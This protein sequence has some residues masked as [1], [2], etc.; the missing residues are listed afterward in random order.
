MG[1]KEITFLLA[2]D[3]II[4]QKI[5][6]NQQKTPGLVNHYSKVTEYRVTVQNFISYVPAM[7]KWNLELKTLPLGSKN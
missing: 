3:K 7:N 6:E 5:S 1:K 2:D 4:L